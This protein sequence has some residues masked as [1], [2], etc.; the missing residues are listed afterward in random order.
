MPSI[1]RTG[2]NFHGW[3]YLG[4]A[5]SNWLWRLLDFYKA[6]SAVASY[7]EAFVVAEARNLDVIFLGSLEDRE[8]VIDLVG[9]VVDEDLYFLG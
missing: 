4:A 8:V 5:R 6:H 2:M 1:L 7:F 9:F 3:S